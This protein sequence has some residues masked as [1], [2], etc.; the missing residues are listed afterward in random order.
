MTYQL[1]LTTLGQQKLAAAASAGGQPVRIAEFAVGQG[2][3]VDFSQRLDQQVL[4]SKRYQAA[5]NGVAAT[6]VVGQYEITCIVP[7][8][9]GGWA[10]R[11]IGLIDSEGSL[12]WVGQVPELQ[13]PV[14]SSTATVDYRIKAVIS[15]DN[16]DVNLVI[17]ANVV[18][19]TQAWVS[20]NFVSN[21]R[22]AQFL[23][24]AY[25]F[26]YPYWSH[27]KSNPKPLFD[28]MFGFETHWRRLEG[29]GLVAVKDGD[30]YI[31]QP[32]LTLG[33]RGNTELATT[34]RPHTYPIY[35]SYLFERYDP[36]TVVETVWKVAADKISINEGAAVRFTVTASNLP[37][38]Q[39]LD[40]IV[41][42]G[43][44]NGDTNDVVVPEKTE[45]GTVILNNGQAIINFTTTS[46]DN[47][48]E[49]QNHV[50]LTVGAPANLSI[51]VPIN[52]AGHHE[53]V[54]HISQ[55]TTDGIDLAEYYKAQS[56]SYPSSTETVRF[57][58]DAG[59][60][61]IAPDT[62]TAAIEAGINWPIGS[63]AT[64][65]NHGRIFGRGGDAG[66]SARTVEDNYTPLA[67]DTYA[68]R[69][70]PL[71]P[72]IAGGDGGT[73]TKGS[74]TIENYGFIAGGGGGGGGSSAFLVDKSYVLPAY[75]GTDYDYRFMFYSVVEAGVGGGAPFGEATYN[76][77]GVKAFNK[78]HKLDIS[79]YYPALGVNDVVLT[80]KVDANLWRGAP[81]YPN[82][83]PIVKEN[84]VYAVRF[85]WRDSTVKTPSGGHTTSYDHI[86][87][88][89]TVPWSNVSN[90][91][92]YRNN[93]LDVIN[94]PLPNMNGDDYS[95]FN[96][97]AGYGNRLE[98]V[99]IAEMQRQGEFMMSYEAKDGALLTGGRGGA[100]VWDS[101][102][103]AQMYGDNYQL[104]DSKKWRFTRAIIQKPAS[105]AQLNEWYGSGATDNGSNFYNDTYTTELD[106]YNDV[107]GGD[108]GN[109]GEAGQAGSTIPEYMAIST[110]DS[111]GYNEL[112]I[113]KVDTT[114]LN[115]FRTPAAQG[116]LAGY[117]K[118]G[119]VTI[120]N[121][122]G[123]VTKG[124]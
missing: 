16:P 54:M 121:L 64:V 123:G 14:A 59:V 42:E 112:R 30:A 100:N 51:N 120:N 74:M 105:R 115:L 52:D 29:I 71:I 119:N 9:Q 38:G 53:T 92:A 78:R 114:E 43:A 6:A 32:M 75:S 24:L 109:V 103:D 94:L 89:V 118:E 98:N 68:S 11:E 12:I 106:F 5:V 33:Q 58:V 20:N 28:A 41:K 46:D 2:V 23:D 83:D 124:R 86:D 63:Q 21:P 85:D 8:D 107:K 76:Y 4:V 72:A 70:H 73:A 93:F 7:Q 36:S 110:P 111:T 27:S 17:D 90:E 57:I 88:V 35:T 65:E 48:E 96:G 40:W 1:L 108:G 87:H 15:I 99:N 3:N 39:I 55:S 60:D 62:D 18:T 66:R 34:D 91:T 81:Q 69:V 101:P 102:F 67:I 37:D 45:S 19:A 49:S 82:P 104:A 116:G 47:I 84:G 50:R 77:T 26:G 95:L 56:G 22:F 31:G 80:A 113:A 79:D 10:I 122:S 61:I 13:K 44:L 117:V 97:I 25:P